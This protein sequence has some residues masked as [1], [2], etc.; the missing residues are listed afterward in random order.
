ME[1]N[2]TRRDHRDRLITTS[3]EVEEA[4]ANYSLAQAEL[5]QAQAEL[6][7]AQATLESQKVAAKSAKSKSARYQAIAASGALSQDLLDEAILDYQQQQQQVFVQQATVEGYQ[8]AISRQQQAISAAKARLNNMG[9]A[10][11][12]SNAEV[13]IAR[14]RISQFHAGGKVTIATLNREQ[15]ALKQ[16]GIENQKQL[17]RHQKQLHQALINRDRT[18]IKAPASGTLFQLDLHNSGQNVQA[19]TAI[20]QIAPE[21][22]SLW[23]KAYVSPQDI[24]QVTV[25]QP[26]QIRISACPYPDYGILKGTVTKI[27]PDAIPVQGN[28]S[29]N[30]INAQ[31]LYEVIIEP[32]SSTF[33]QGNSHC[34]LQ[35]GMEGR[36]DILAEKETVLRFLL[37]KARLIVSN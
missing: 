21:N 14:K 19:G 10:L 12:P 37:R 18:I 28:T 25:G 24:S 33:G 32:E 15:E 36:A 17:E 2:R 13:E 27:S 31:S 4:Q 8:S 1:L 26:A 3:A 22:T 30:T 35:L 7:S 5:A 16:Q 6:Q 11:N 29:D 34:V 9:A 20:A 23:A